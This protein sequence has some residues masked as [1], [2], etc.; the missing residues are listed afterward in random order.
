MKKFFKKIQE[1]KHNIG[2]LEVG[3]WD[4]EA[5]STFTTL[6]SNQCN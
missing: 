6:K 4:V 1:E 5:D 3:T 2:T